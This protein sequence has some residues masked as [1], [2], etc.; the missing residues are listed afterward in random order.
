M[1]GRWES[2]RTYIA[3]CARLLYWA[4]FRP[5]TFSDWLWEIDPDLGIDENPF[6]YRARFSSNPRLR[7][8]AGQV[9]WLSATV[10]ILAPLFAAGPFAWSWSFRF[11]LGWWAGLWFTRSPIVSAPEKWI[12][13]FLVVTSILVFVLG[14]LL[15][16][17]PTLLNRLL[18]LLPDAALGLLQ[19]W[20]PLVADWLFIAFGVA[21]GVAWTLGVLRV[22]F[23]LPKLLWMFGLA[24]M[25]RP[26]RY[27]RWLRYLPPRF[28]ELIILPLP[29]MGEFIARAYRENQAAAQQMIDYLI[30]STNQQRAAQEEESLYWRAELRE[31]LATESPRFATAYGEI[32]DRW[33]RILEPALWTLEERAR[34]SPEIPQVYIAGPPLDP[35]TAGERFRGRGDIFREIG[36]LALSDVKPVILLY[37]GRRTGKTSALK[38]LP[39]RV[40]PEILPLFVDVQGLTATTLKGLAEYLAVQIV[41]SARRARNFHLPY[42]DPAPWPKTPLSPYRNGWTGWK[43]SP[44]TGLFCSA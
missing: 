35:E 33:L 27:S 31:S 7:H 6:R 26:G 16:F 37:G 9:W 22:Y 42:L 5:Y 29:F 8:Y 38:Y 12:F 41:E 4:Y 34:S 18:P 28:N 1:A 32:V 20:L 2:L 14:G 15:Q 19:A 23:W 21:V 30:T 40:G 17:S 44:A 24:L 36:T 10:P 11:L 3:E 39:L 25:A 13:R 43:E